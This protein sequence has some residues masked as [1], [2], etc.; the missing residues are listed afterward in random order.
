METFAVI[1]TET[2]W[3]NWVMSIGV[4]V[5]DAAT[6]TLLDSRYYVLT[7]EYLSGG[8]FSGALFPEGFGRPTVCRRPQAM[9]AL[10]R[11]LALHGVEDIFAY[12]ARFDRGHLPELGDL[13]W[14][15]IM[16]L[17]AYRQ[18]NPAIPAHLPCCSTG[19]LKSG[20]G[21][22]PMLRLLAR[23]KCYCESHNALGD[24]MDELQIMRLLG[25]PVG[26]YI[27]L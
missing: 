27:P 20:Y 3:D 1:D 4:V 5:A 16:A 8:M 21:V 13:Q 19:R 15:D 12:N 17:A 2:T 25:H 7:P 18:H 23:D 22:E 6:F 11:F 10:R 14:Y 9:A 26:R 24:A